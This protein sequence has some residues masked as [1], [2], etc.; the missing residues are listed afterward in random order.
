MLWEAIDFE[1]K[2]G[3]CEEVEL[4][5]IDVKM[6]VVEVKLVNVEVRSVN[7]EV[8]LGVVGRKLVL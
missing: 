4:N 5:F 8:K 1:C 7:V 3:Y 2:S 6:V